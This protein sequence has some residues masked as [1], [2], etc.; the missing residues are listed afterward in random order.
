MLLEQLGGGFMRIRANDHEGPHLVA[1]VCDAVRSDFSSYPAVRPGRRSQPGVFRSTIS[2]QLFPL[3]SSLAVP[4]R[5]GRSIPSCAGWFCYQEKQ[6]D[7]VL[8]V[9][10]RSPLLGAMQVKA[11]VPAD[12]AAR[13]TIMLNRGHTSHMGRQTSETSTPRFATSARRD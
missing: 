10:M 11:R 4:L 9:L 12:A 3:V 13:E 2:R 1:C 6:R 7:Y 8:F 5:E